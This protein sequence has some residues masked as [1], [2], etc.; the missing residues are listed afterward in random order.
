MTTLRFPVAG[1]WGAVCTA[2]LFAVLAHLVNTRMDV[3]P[4]IETGPIKFT[5]VRIEPPI[6][7]TRQQKPTRKPAAPTPG[8][9]HVGPGDRHLDPPTHWVRPAVDVRMPHDNPRTLGTDRDVVPIVRV[10]PDYPQRAI[11]GNVEGWV[12]VQYTITA[13]GAVKDAFVVDASPRAVFDDAALKAIARWRYNP[14]IE[15]GTPAER[16]GMQT[17]IRFELENTL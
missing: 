8:T 7:T 11:H 16:V 17:V 2:A 12:K 3:Q 1:I 4:S 9:F 14:R 13:T 6:E 5:P 10:N 15:D